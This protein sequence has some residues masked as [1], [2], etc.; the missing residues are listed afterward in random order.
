MITI[1]EI[2][3][4]DAW[5]AFL[6]RE[7]PHTFL[8]SW[9]WG[10]FNQALGSRIWRL[11]FF[12][13]IDLIGV[14]LVIKVS[15]RRGSFFLCP[16]GPIVVSGAEDA[17]LS[18]LLAYLKECAREE[19][20]GFIRIA[21]LFE[22]SQKNQ[23]MFE[24]RSCRT[25]PV[26]MVHPEYAWI[27]DVT[28]S[29]DNLFSGMRKQTR[30]CVKLARDA[31][32]TIMKSTDPRDIEVFNS[33]YQKTV[34][35]RHF[36]PFSRRYLEQEFAAFA[37]DN[38]ALLLFSWYRNEPISAAFVIFAYGSAFYH[39]GASVLKYP[40]LP[41]SHLLQWEALCEAK[42]RGCAQYNFWGVAPKNTPSHPWAGLTLFK[43]GFGGASEEYL[44][45]YD[46]VLRPSYW[47]TWGIEKLRTIQR[48]L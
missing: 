22:N 38:Q 32:V 26:H 2:T 25:S 30:H 46:Y 23:Q 39:H 4:R 47:I 3:S 5:D 16:H 37:R 19:S 34:D 17:I 36:I 40:K 12:Y 6:D 7:R 43:K 41:A 27:L 24:A 45:A 10:S 35:R 9:N 31:G 14:A 28:P 29:E 11:G 15:A 48:G 8:Q 21:S 18:A 20:V 1:Q 42:K 33:L 44:H 13:G